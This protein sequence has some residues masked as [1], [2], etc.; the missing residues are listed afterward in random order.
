MRNRTNRVLRSLIIVLLAATS[1]GAIPVS[2]QAPACVNEPGLAF[3]DANGDG[4]LSLGELQAVASQFPDPDLQALVAQAAAEPSFG[5]IQYGGCSPS[6][7]SGGGS[8][9]SDAGS[10]GS[11]GSGA[12]SGGGGT[13]TIDNAP[14]D[15]PAEVDTDAPV[16]TDPPTA[17]DPVTETITEATS[18][19]CTVVELYP[20]YPGY[21]GNIT[22]VMPLWNG[23][24]D[25]ECL[26]TLEQNDPEFGRAEE[27]QANQLAADALGINGSMN[28]WTWE[29][30]MLIEAERG[31][32]ASC[33]SCLMIDTDVEPLRQDIQPESDD[34]RLRTGIIG[35]S[36]AIRLISNELGINDPDQVQLIADFFQEDDYLLRVTAYVMGSPTQ[37]AEE[38]YVEMQRWVQGV[39]SPNGISSFVDPSMVLQIAIWERGGYTPV[40]E[41][42]TTDDQFVSMSYGFAFAGLFFPEAEWDG[43]QSELDASIDGWLSDPE[44]EPTTP[45]AIHM[46]QEPAWQDYRP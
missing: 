11:G 3:F 5:G 9:G 30:W 13:T 17:A 2:A 25:Y 35:Q 21:R 20:G 42:A 39:A 32:P 27:D 19:D 34:Y 6:S 24:G 4:V 46:Q 23:Q 26:E 1:M 22:G 8:G 44:T 10:G 33:Y 37:N 16:V 43:I 15:S 45:L 14:T 40:P 28:L 18:P 29:N 36:E 41:S 31:L 38:L 7:G 12:G